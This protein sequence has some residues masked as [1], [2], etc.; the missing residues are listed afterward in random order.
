M[1]NLILDLYN[2]DCIKTGQFN[3]KSG[4]SSPIYIDLKNIISYPYILNNIAKEIWEEIKNIECDVICGVPYGALP[5]A[6]LISCNHNIPMVLVRKEKKK[7]GTSKLIE[8]TYKKG[9]KCILIEDVIT[10]GGSLKTV[11][12]QLKQHD[13][14]VIKIIV[15][16]DRRNISDKN[17]LNDYNLSYLFSITDIINC[18]NS[19]NKIDFA[20][21]SKIKE[22]FITPTTASL[23]FNERKNLTQNTLSKKIFALMELKKTNLCFSADI[24]DPTKL[25]NIIN[26]IG[27]HICILKLHYDIILNFSDQLIKALQTIAKSKKFFIFE[28]RKFC[29]IGSTFIN[30]Y[31][32]KIRDW[33]DLITVNC[34]AGEGIIKSFSQVNHYKKNGLLL[35]HEMS[36]KDNLINNEYKK[37][38][39]KYTEKYKKDIVGLITQK[40]DIS[41]NDL[42]YLTP[43]VN[44]NISKDKIDQQYRTPD[45]AIIRDNC[46]III[47]GR[48][49]YDSDEPEKTA[50]IYK[51]LAWNAYQLKIKNR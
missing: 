45:D 17:I 49:I 14:E 3:L 20:E 51:F 1:N 19:N 22:Y 41:N 23:S 50:E 40:N 24:T 44:I 13:I 30:Q 15:I 16:C 8:G 18:L 21:Y 9:C 42:L 34:L 11:I 47:V 2:K 48:G 7:Y 25:L 28:D 4:K 46:D 36:T 38:V 29:D 35:I 31:T 10:T 12:H 43:G 6:S 32:N 5:I 26:Q 39:V 37:N 33:S 27:Q